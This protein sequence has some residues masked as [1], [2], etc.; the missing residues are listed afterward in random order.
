MSDALRAQLRAYRQGEID[1]DELLAELVQYPFEEHLIG[2]IDHHRE[3]RTGLPEVILAEGKEPGDVSA[4]FETYLSRGEM[5]IATRVRGAVREALEPL[6]DELFISEGPGVCAT[7]PPPSP[8]EGFRQVAVVSAGTLD[9]H[10]AEEAAVCAELFGN[11]VARIADVGVAGLNRLLPELPKLRA[12]GIVIAVAGMEGALP[13]VLAGLVTAPI[14]ATPTSVGY[15]ANFEGLSALLTMLN[16]C[17]PGISVVNI[18]NGFGAA[19][20]ATK[21]NAAFA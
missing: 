10:V 21:I 15:G 9:R 7:R 8:R 19:A 14:V 11:P 5:L 3:V 2:R 4:L 17:A 12:A 18:D 20:M 1:E 6:A 13:S 16:A